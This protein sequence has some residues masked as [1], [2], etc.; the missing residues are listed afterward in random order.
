MS[1]LDDDFMRRT[2]DESES[3]F[4]RALRRNDIDDLDAIL[5]EDAEFVGPDGA[6]LD[7]S[8]DLTAHRAGTF[9]LD[10]MDE[11][12]R[13]LQVIGGVGITRVKL[14]LRGSIANAPL[15]AVLIYTRT[16][17][18]HGENWTIIAAHASVVPA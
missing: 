15:D 11:L 5:H 18:R 7:K 9:V 13:R 10:A 12:S 14:H 8:A 4:Q 17:L 16:W 3:R 2:L 1:D 6:T